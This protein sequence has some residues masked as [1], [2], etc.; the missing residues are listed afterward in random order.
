MYASR[1]WNSQTA[2]VGRKYILWRAGATNHAVV[3][4]DHQL[5]MADVAL[6][7]LRYNI[8]SKRRTDARISLSAASRYE[9]G[10]PLGVNFNNGCRKTS[11]KKRKPSHQSDIGNWLSTP[12][13]ARKCIIWRWIKPV[14]EGE[15]NQ[16]LAKSNPAFT[17]KSIL[18]QPSNSH[19]T[20]VTG[21]WPGIMVEYSTHYICISF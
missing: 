11:T 2:E 21:V 15:S 20:S 6:N 7:S 14:F 10:L 19:A 16:S 18:P 1:P 5:M 8:L 3:T 17:W 4:T 13:V 9:Q 12:P